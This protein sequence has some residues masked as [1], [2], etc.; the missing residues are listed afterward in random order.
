MNFKEK[1][2]EDLRRVEKI[3][4]F[5]QYAGWVEKFRED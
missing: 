3:T 1:I 2:L 4:M 5:Q